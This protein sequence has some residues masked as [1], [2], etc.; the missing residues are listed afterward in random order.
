MWCKFCG[1]ETENPSSFCTNRCKK[2][3]QNEIAS[4]RA[5][6]FSMDIADRIKHQRFFELCRPLGDRM[7]KRNCLSCQGNFK[8]WLNQRICSVCLT[9]QHAVGAL[10][11]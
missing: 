4:G 2:S 7:T 11:Q 3:F 5:R 10:A 9:K 8:A 6:A 1:I